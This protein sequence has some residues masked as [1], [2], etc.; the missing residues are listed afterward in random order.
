MALWGNKD[1][2]IGTAGPAAAGFASSISL[3]YATRV[4]TGAGTSFGNA[5]AAKTGDVIEFG[6]R[7]AG[8][9]YFGS[10]TIVSI[11]STIECAIGSTAGLNGDAIADLHL[12]KINEET[13]WTEGVN[14]WSTRND[15]SASLTEY[16]HVVPTVAI[17]T[18]NDANR[19]GVGV[20]VLAIAEDGSEG[21]GHWDGINIKVG[22]YYVD[23]DGSSGTTGNKEVV[24]IGKASLTALSAVAVGETC[25]RF[26]PPPG[27]ATGD[28]LQDQPGSIAG[29]GSTE[30]T[31]AAGI[32]G[33]TW[34]TVH[35][36]AAHNLLVGDTFRTPVDTTDYEIL[37]VSAGL[38]TISIGVANPGSG[39]SMSAVLSAG[40][41]VTF[42]SATIVTMSQG[43]GVAIAAG[44]GV[45]VMGD[46]VSLGAT[47]C[48]P[49]TTGTALTFS[50]YQGGYDAFIYGVAGTGLTATGSESIG[51]KYLVDSVG[52]VGVTTYTDNQGNL[53]VKKETLASL[54]GITTADT[55][56]Y[57]AY[58]PK[59]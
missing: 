50:R 17:T 45:S 2:G 29:T 39:A 23:G 28:H 52:W 21:F 5:G 6:S 10:A 46:Y 13:T 16:G 3:N 34:L 15:S 19:P 4:V 31:V 57:P 20:S 1:A 49:V 7:A 27:M 35:N 51:D 8:A 38:G 41:A 22:D 36:Y 47:I 43:V 24:A 30:G 44:L 56:I 59:G 12:Y 9:T 48:T 40:A 32:A 11:A 26:S 18:S 55:A 42:S 25:V 54:S 33:T 53:R 37:T 14:R 58:P